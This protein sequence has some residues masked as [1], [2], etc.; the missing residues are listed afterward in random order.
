MP[1]SLPTSNH[2]RSSWEAPHVASAG[3]AAAGAASP[4]RNAS[5]VA[6][7][8]AIIRSST[9]RNGVPAGECAAPVISI[10]MPTYNSER[11]IEIALRSVAQQTYRDRTEV[12]VVD[13][14]STDRT[15]QI[16][17]RYGCRVIENL[18]V[19]PEYAKLIGLS[20]AAGRYAVFLDSD[21]ALA[22]ERS[23]ERKCV[24]SR[25]TPT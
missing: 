25:N 11:T 5:G 12:L 8:R 19:Q 14:G 20:H 24:R 10:I 1:S 4:L 17:E 6:I 23:L 2:T 3:Y 22:D 13:G 7:F 9:V 21:E 15:K 16:A 18:R